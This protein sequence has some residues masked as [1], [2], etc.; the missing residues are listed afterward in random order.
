MRLLSLL[1]AIVQHPVAG[2]IYVAHPIP[3]CE[4]DISVLV[5]LG[6][7]KFLYHMP[8]WRQ[9]KRLRYHGI[10]LPYSTLCSLVN[11]TSQ[12]LEPLWHLLLKEI[13]NSG[14]LLKEKPEL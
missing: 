4:M 2:F 5:L 8:V 9:Q 1:F 7:E 6:I 12:V 3:K 13:K 11:R 14:L 10:N